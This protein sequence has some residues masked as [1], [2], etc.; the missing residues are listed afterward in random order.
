MTVLRLEGPPDPELARQLTEFEAVFTYPLGPSSSFRISH[1]DDYARFFR[2]MGRAACFVARRNDIVLGVLA[3]VLR[4][5][6]MPGG[7]A[8]EI[9]YLADL[10]IAPEARGSRTLHRLAM[11]AHDWARPFTN[12]AFAVVMGGTSR[13][14][15]RYT[16]RAGIPRF[17]AA[18]E[19]A[20]LRIPSDLPGNDAS[21]YRVVDQPAGEAALARLG[22]ACHR[23]S[24]GDPAG[25]SLRSPEWLCLDDGA[26]VGR[27]EDTRR[28]K[29]LFETG[30]EEILSAHLAAFAFADPASGAEL[31]GAACRRIRAEGLPALF[32]AVA[33]ADVAPLIGHLTGGPLEASGIIVAPAT[34]Y[35]SGPGTG[36]PWL[37]N[38]SEI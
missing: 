2:S 11:A 3:C 8:S 35:A 18:C 23:V 10:K 15:D 25:R 33:P 4:T 31:L 17:Q 9:A 37:V 5:V 1:G 24:A 26:A 29:R 20:V 16:G 36:A 22:T 30:G 32:T 12:R 21:K 38:T 34:V 6:H 27:L 7:G 19:I 13:T 14:P 28:A